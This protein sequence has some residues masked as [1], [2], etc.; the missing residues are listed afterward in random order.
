MNINII[1]IIV[2]GGGGGAAA[3]AVV[4]VAGSSNSSSSS[5][6]SS[7][8]GGGS[9][10]S[11]SSSS[12]NYCCCCVVH[13]FTRIPETSGC[14]RSRPLRDQNHP[15]F[16]PQT[17]QR[18]GMM[19]QS[20]SER[21]PRRP[22]NP[23][24]TRPKTPHRALSVTPWATLSSPRASRKPDH[25]PPEVTSPAQLPVAWNTRMFASPMTVVTA[26]LCRLKAAAV[27][28]FPY[29]FFC[30][31]GHRRKSQVRGDVCHL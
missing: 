31:R 13:S 1:I 11:S 18:K 8:S 23:S 6:S 21:R 16:L 29:P 15:A 25:H 14:H 10:S 24:G 4:V 20:A 27:P 5:S 22:T 19:N 7:S 12:S 3:A 2:G 26:Q 9:S 17:A 30:R 28:E